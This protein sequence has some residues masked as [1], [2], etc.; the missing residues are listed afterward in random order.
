MHFSALVSLI[1]ALLLATACSSTPSEGDDTGTGTGTGGSSEAS[2]SE[3]PT[4]GSPDPACVP[5]QQ[6]GCPCLDAPDGVQVC[7]AAGSGYEPCM[8]T[9]A[10]GSDSDA[11][12]DATT[13][14]TT[15][16]A[17]TDPATTDITTD[18]GTST[19]GET[20][21]G[22]TTLPDATTFLSDTSAGESSTGGDAP[23]GPCPGGTDE[24]CLDGEQCVT[25]NANGMPWSICTSGE[26][27][28]DAQCD[29]T[30]DDLCSDAPGDGEGV[31][32]CLPFEC[33]DNS[34]CPNGMNCIDS[35]F[36]P[37]VCLWQ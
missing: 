18:P 22:E 32:Y 10:S 24:E 13:N 23:Y 28:F 33:D 31:D 29:A 26:C 2:T 36:G 34:P 3:N 15:D 16:P 25:G 1:P 27:D 5:G 37:S 21:S 11:T 19:S 6:I 4:T 9:G 12:T 8:C 20:T 14:I 30:R 17:T 35:M 7:N